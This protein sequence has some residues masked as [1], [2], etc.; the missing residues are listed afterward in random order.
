L[1][2]S[3][4]F[5]QRRRG[6]RRIPVR[7]E[8]AVHDAIDLE[9]AV[10]LVSV[11]LGEFNVEISVIGPEDFDSDIDQRI[12]QLGTLLG[13]ASAPDVTRKHGGRMWLTS[14]T[15]YPTWAVLADRDVDN[16]G[17]RLHFI[18]I[19]VAESTSEF[20]LDLDRV[21]T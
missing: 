18:G 8:A 13:S 21:S 19:D 11:V 9:R 6:F 3:Q 17:G 1:G 10:D 5:N 16:I 2:F 4:V 14:A 7:C 20:A 15:Q 12:G